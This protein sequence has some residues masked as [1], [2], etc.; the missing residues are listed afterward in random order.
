METRDKTMLR[1]LAS[2]TKSRQSW[3]VKRAEAKYSSSRKPKPEPAFLTLQLPP[4]VLNVRTSPHRKA[5]LRTCSLRRN[6]WPGCQ[7]PNEDSLSVAVTY[8]FGFEES[9]EGEGRSGSTNLRAHRRRE[10]GSS[11]GTLSTTQTEGFSVAKFIWN[12]V[13]IMLLE[14][15]WCSDWQILTV[16]GSDSAATWHMLV[17]DDHHLEAG[18]EEYR[19]AL[20]TFFIVCCIVGAPLSW[21]GTSGGET[22]TWVGFELLHRTRQLGISQRRADWFRKWTTEVAS[23]GSVHM[24]SFEEGL[25][26][27]MYVAGSLSTRG[28]FWSSLSFHLS[29]PARLGQGSFSLPEAPGSADIG[30]Q[31]P[32]L[33]D[34]DVSR[35]A[36]AQSRCP[37]Q[38]R[39]RWNRRM[40]PSRRSVGTGQCQIVKMV[41]ARDHQR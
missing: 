28:L 21:N 36:C 35:P 25:G 39:P 33:F 22:V 9:H 4:L 29:S 40:V 20:M 16:C 15:S 23:S 31:A 27:V 10:R 38:F 6:S 12:Y 11:A 1:W 13:S 2:L 18:G 3:R 34:D 7:Y 30:M 8:C 17:A 37:C 26:R 19:S 5:C 32:R 14:H 24:A 41:L